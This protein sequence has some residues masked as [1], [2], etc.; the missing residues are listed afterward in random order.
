MQNGMTGILR[1]TGYKMDW[2][3]RH[4]LFEKVQKIR[5][6]IRSC[7]NEYQLDS[8]QKMSNNLISIQPECEEKHI[9]SCLLIAEYGKMLAKILKSKIL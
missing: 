1:I 2:H 8:A 7:V 6:V 9:A 5:S 4:R 3:E